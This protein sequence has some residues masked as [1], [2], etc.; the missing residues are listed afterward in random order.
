M[1][2][3]ILPILLHAEELVAFENYSKSGRF[4]TLFSEFIKIDLPSVPLIEVSIKLSVSQVPSST[5]EYPAPSPYAYIRR[6]SNPEYEW[7]YELDLKN[8]TSQ[9]TIPYM[10]VSSFLV[11]RI[12]GGVYNT[13]QIFAGYSGP[14]LSYTIFVSW[15]Y[16]NSGYFA[17]KNGKVCDVP[18]IESEDF[19]NDTFAA[20][21]FV[22]LT[23]QRLT[24]NGTNIKAS[25]LNFDF[26]SQGEN[27]IDVV[28][29]NTGNW[30]I[31]GDN[32]FD[33]S[34][35]GCEWDE[36]GET[37]CNDKNVDFISE[38]ALYEQ[39]SNEFINY[40][41][42]ILAF[43]VE[44][45]DVKYMF[46]IE[47]LP[48][49]NFW[50]GLNSPLKSD[51]LPY[52]PVGIHYIS[53]ALNNSRI[54]LYKTIMGSGFCNGHP[55]IQKAGFYTCDC[56]QQYSG[57]HCENQSMTDFSYYVQLA[58][59]AGSNLSMLPALITG[60]LYGFYAEVVI[61]FSTMVVSMAYHLCD[62]KFYCFF[63]FH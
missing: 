27:F 57:R 23:T 28:W 60:T 14:Q 40:E 35:Q 44:E 62:Y 38:I 37:F 49:N 4:S 15:K 41:A 6:D 63:Y 8:Y 31:V 47:S 42:D 58:A 45:E 10:P 20:I 3:L 54:N 5:N 19:V 56:Y 1:F 36:A 34:I 9:L 24:I 13:L 11:I 50:L 12:D 32:S 16:C 51:F 53:L 52:L 18:I 2:Y 29:P 59:L 48:E 17:S 43:K 33:F 22:P 61:F 7:D 25:P 26:T 46:V 21:V 30:F 55:Y 39:T